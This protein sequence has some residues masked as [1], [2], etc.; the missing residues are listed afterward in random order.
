MAF[1]CVENLIN[2]LRRSL[3]L[4]SRHVPVPRCRVI[5]VFALLW[6]IVTG[7]VAAQE[8]SQFA[9]RQRD[10]AQSVA[11][12]GIN[13][14]GPVDWN[15]ELPLVDVFGMA[16]PWISQREGQPWGKGP[17]LDLDEH[18]WVRRL[19]RGCWAETL[20]CSVGEGHYPSGR[21]TVFYRGRGKFTFGGSAKIV[22]QRPG[23]IVLKV[24]AKRGPI[25][26][27]IVQTDPSD[28]VRDIHVILPG[29]ETAWRENPFHPLFLRRWKG[30]ACIRFMD[31]MHTNNSDIESWEDRP[32]L[33][34]ATF[35][36]KGIPLE[37]MIDLCNRLGADAWFCMPHRANDDYV[38]RFAQMVHRR[39]APDRKVYIEY[40]NEVW[41]SIFGQHRY[42]QERARELGLG[43]KDRPWEG[44]GMFY[45]RRSVEIFGIW[46]EVFGGRDRLVRVL[47]WQ[48]GNVWWFENILL[49]THNA[50]RHCDALAIAPYLSMMVRGQGRGLMAS[51]V[52]RWSVDQVLDYVEREALPRSIDQMQRTRRLADQYRL[53]LIA[54]EGGQHLVGVAGGENNERVTKLLQAANRHPRMGRIYGRYFRGWEESGGGLFC[55]YSSVARPGKWGCWGALPYWDTP[56]SQSPKYQAL[57]EWA[58]RL[59]QPMELV[60]PSR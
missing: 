38:R 31:W 5:P 34:D 29:F 27:R 18:G 46:E 2:Y 43:P 13:L 53:K 37:W 12:V 32:Q 41:N 22:S 19:E 24:D 15:S 36:K 30:V 45:A 48:S 42:A 8:L 17:P 35:A 51:E 16:R 1:W 47:A 10:G 28:Y 56:P 59:G 9:R 39:L 25:F 33:E 7:W 26:L 57:V 52:E 40:S 3:R 60:G 50:H 44:A 23:R 55:Y 4:G 58:Q 6:A 49:P 14:A 54:Y 20:L 21:Y 11:S